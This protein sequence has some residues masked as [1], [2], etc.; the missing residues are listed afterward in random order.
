MGS[1][2]TSVRLQGR[3]QA[4]SNQPPLVASVVPDVSGI[5]KVFDYVVPA[6][7]AGRASVGARVRINLN[8][9]RVSGWIVS[10]GPYGTHGDTSLGIERLAP[11]VSVSG[12]GVEPELVSLTQ[13]VATKWWGPWRAA[14]S[15]ASAPR[16]TDRHVH[17]RRGVHTLIADD[18]V[19]IAARELA[20]LGGGLLVVPPLSSALA[21]VAALASSGPVL[22]IC[23]TQRM[24]AMGAAA[25]RRK[26]FSTAI[27]PEEWESAR[28]GVDVV[29]GARSA[30]FAPCPDVSAIVVIDEHDESLHEERSPT[31]DATTVAI[32]RARAAAVPIIATSAVPSAESE[33]A[34]AG[35]RAV[36]E[37]A[38]QWPQ[39]EVIN[40]ADVPVASS[41]LSS[42]LF[43]SIATRG[44]TTVVVLNTKGKA[45][46][47][48]CKSCRAV[49]SCAACNALLTQDADGELRCDRCDIACGSVC[50]SCGRSA[51]IVPRGGV[52]QLRT[53]LQA[54]SVNPVIEITADSSDEWTKGNVFIGTEAV[55]HRVPFA[56]CVVFADI[57][58]DLG[59]PRMSAPH[60]VLA[61]I[62]RAARTV[63]TNGKVIVQ[64]RQMEHPL[65]VALQSTHIADSLR[66]WAE[67]DLAQRQMLGLPPFGVVARVTIAAPRSIDEVTL[68]ENVHVARDEES[69]LV[70]AM[71]HAVMDEALQSIRKELGT[72][73]RI[74]M[75]PRRF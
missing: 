56:D 7:L 16:V 35:R 21:V 19:S 48:V 50:V 66:Q 71:S 75:N 17:S 11:L 38:T 47:I 18:A 60:E 8:G 32:E 13:W 33:V 53:Q 23:P 28:G 74:H 64:T 59:A 63:G 69:V 3:C 9:R 30:V 20:S 49:Q 27:V 72:A 40:L 42:E 61:L 51:F 10:L 44:S 12:V 36:V 65:M 26:G 73:V 62:A 24:A 68:P 58:R 22:A 37:T 45:R 15:S 5:D 67:K 41:L 55:L 34:F 54:S 2:V 39:V 43:E 25:L 4:L 14:L 52:S 1:I 6:E 70:R 57:D 31:W 29:I 46:L